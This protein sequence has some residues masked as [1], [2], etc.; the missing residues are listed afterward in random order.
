MTLKMVTYESRRYLVPQRHRWLSLLY[1]A[2]QRS[3]ATLEEAILADG[4][5]RISLGRPPG[6]HR[7]LVVTPRD[8]GKS[9]FVETSDH[10]IF[11]EGDR[12]LTPTDRKDINHLKHVIDKLEGHLPKRFKGFAALGVS[13]ET[14]EQELVRLFPFITIE[15][16]TRG[17]DEAVEVLVRTTS[18]CDEACPFCSAPTH[19]SPDQEM[20]LACMDAM[21]ELSPG[22]LLSITGGEPTLKRS[23]FAEVKYALSLQG[24]ARVQVQTNAVGFGARVDPGGLPLNERLS[25]F[26]SLHAVDSDIYDQMTG[27]KGLLDFALKGIARILDAGHQM[28]LNTVVTSANLDHLDEIAELVA[29]RWRDQRLVWHFSTLICPEQS[30]GAENYL[31]RYSE[32]VP[33]LRRVGKNAAARG[34]D[35]ESLGASTYASVPACFIPGDTRVQA[36]QVPRVLRSETGYDDLTR[37]WVKTTACRGCPVDGTCLGVPRAYAQRFGLA[38]LG[39]EEG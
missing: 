6:H 14:P 27:T 7:E 13:A 17:S 23:L 28:T 26:V 33:Q 10:L 12:E 8:S 9:G 22:A 25:F 16:A 31:V 29:A 35:V 3:G 20:V 5:L 1:A 11:Y 19:D 4:E 38:E 30:P 34:V 32:L 24:I 21:A 15:R 39:W 36:E 37:P 18:A 2:M